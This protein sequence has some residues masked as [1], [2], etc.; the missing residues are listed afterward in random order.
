[1]VDKILLQDQGVTFG[2]LFGPEEPEEPPAEEEEV[3]E[4]VEKPKKVEKEKLPKFK[5]VEEVVRDPKIHYYMVPRLGSYLAIKLEY[6]SCLFEE[7][8]DAAVVDFQEV[9]AKRLEQD[10]KKREFDEAQ[11]DLKQEKEDNGEVFVPEAKEWEV[12]Q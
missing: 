3:P 8:F 6:E 12:I 2:A 9:Q 7:A 10:V 11:A 5:L 1:M 4:G